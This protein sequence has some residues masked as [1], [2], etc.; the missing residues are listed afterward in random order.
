MIYITTAMYCEAKPFIKYLNLKRDNSIKKFQVF[1]NEQFVLIISGTGVISSSIATTYLLT[2]FNS[3][4]SD[5]FINIG[6]CGGKNKG[7]DKGEV[8]LCN[9]IIHHD[10]KRTYYSDI[11]FKHPFREGSLETFSN[12]VNKDMFSTIK[13]DIVDMEGAGTF[14]AASIFLP[15]HRIYCIKIVS[16][17]LD[18][19]SLTKEEISKLLENKVPL[20]SKWIKEIEDAYSLSYKIFTDEEEKVLEIVTKN[21]KLTITMEYKLRELAKY[22]KIHSKDLIEVI[23]PFLNITSKTKK[24]GK[25]YF[26]RLKKRLSPF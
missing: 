5:T 16:D 10:T 12:V 20:I 14:K 17:F 7:L 25:D 8:V 19:E 13:G 9:K 22:Y 6:I 23:K 26:E 24:E 2:E 18:S 4:P 1:K 15:P 21:L 11:I 3:K